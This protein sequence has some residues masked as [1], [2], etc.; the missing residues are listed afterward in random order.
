MQ[1]GP[2]KWDVET[3]RKNLKKVVWFAKRGA[4]KINKI[5]HREIC[6]RLSAPQHS[7]GVSDCQKS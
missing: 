7:T 5:S 4:K 3:Y 6:R 1:V 2:N